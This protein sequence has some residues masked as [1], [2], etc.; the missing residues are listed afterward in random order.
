MRR[1]MKRA[2]EVK[3]EHIKR[4]NR[5]VNVGVKPTQKPADN[6]Q[7]SNSMKAGTDPKSFAAELSDKLNAFL[8]KQ[9]KQKE[10]QEMEEKL[11]KVGS[12]YPIYILDYEMYYF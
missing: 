12:E 4:G 10:R 7:N 11:K 9:Q 1:D 5:D 8:Q 3:N 2:E 6:Q